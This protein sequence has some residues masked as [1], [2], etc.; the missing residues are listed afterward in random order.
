MPPENGP[1]DHSSAAPRTPGMDVR[2][3]VLGEAHVDR[4]V[5]ATTELD[6]RFQAYITDAAWGQVWGN[7]DLDRPTRSLITI[8]LLAA[9][10]HE[11][12]LEMHLRASQRTGAS[13]T[14]IIETLMHV[15]LYAGVP[16]AN[17]AFAALKRVLGPDAEGGAT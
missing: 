12:E 7:D 17:N 8:A 16:A 9:L 1:S 3:A 11:R 15:A 13:T 2:R 4:A 6:E 5:A 10:G 14:E